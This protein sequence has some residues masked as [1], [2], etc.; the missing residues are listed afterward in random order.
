MINNNIMKES[1]KKRYLKSIS[2]ILE[3]SVHDQFKKS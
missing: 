2:D 1:R 3:W